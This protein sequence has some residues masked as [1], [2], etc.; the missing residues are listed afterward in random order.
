MNEDDDEDDDEDEDE[1]MM[2]GR[3]HGLQWMGQSK[4]KIEYYY[5]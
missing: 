1:E 4:N 5:I 3:I 2:R